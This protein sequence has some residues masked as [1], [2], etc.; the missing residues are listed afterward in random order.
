[1]Q[2]SVIAQ[3]DPMD[4]DPGELSFHSSLQIFLFDRT[5]DTQVPSKSVRLLAYSAVPGMLLSSRL[6]FKA[7]SVIAKQQQ[8]PSSDIV[9]KE[10]AG[11]R[12]PEASST[13]TDSIGMKQDVPGA[14]VHF[15]LISIIIYSP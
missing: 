1:V 9:N 15:L 2:E 8:A 13:R 6:Y 14:F 11:L 4:V 10:P 3:E 5:S 12:L 7:L